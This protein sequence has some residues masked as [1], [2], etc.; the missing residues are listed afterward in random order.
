MLS[1]PVWHQEVFIFKRCVIM[2]TP[3]ARV[4]IWTLEINNNDGGS[5][6]ANTNA[7]KLN[8][9]MIWELMLDAVT[10]REWWGNSLPGS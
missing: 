9:S 10:W 5:Y 8:G 1:F 7:I 3:A 4:F 2:L 6:S